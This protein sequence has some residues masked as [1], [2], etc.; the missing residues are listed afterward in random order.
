MAFPFGG[1]PRLADYIGQ[2]RK[3]HGASASSGSAVDHSGK[4]HT[5]TKITLPNGRSV[6]AVGITQ[7]DYLTPS[8]IAYLDR[9]L[10]INSP[11][12]SVDPP[13]DEPS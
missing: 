2:A 5:A 13:D 3:D 4:G 7:M 9:R 1:H 12:F 11:Y 10:G 8:M 6:V